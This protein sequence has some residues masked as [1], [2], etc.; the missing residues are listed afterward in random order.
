MIHSKVG[1]PAGEV[2]VACCAGCVYSRWLGVFVW[3]SASCLVR[4]CVLSSLKESQRAKGTVTINRSFVYNE[5]YS[6]QEGGIGPTFSER[7]ADYLFRCLDSLPNPLPKPSC[8]TADTSRSRRSSRIKE[9]TTLVR[10]A[11]ALYVLVWS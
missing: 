5:I 11:Y 9:L 2:C 1:V 3:V 8:S 6:Y 10:I 7:A 4:A